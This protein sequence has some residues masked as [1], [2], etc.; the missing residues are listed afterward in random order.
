MSQIIEFITEVFGLF[1]LGLVGIILTVLVG[2]VMT[3][4]FV[5]SLGLSVVSFR[6]CFI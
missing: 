4:L 5:K 1:I 2:I 3:S 6:Y